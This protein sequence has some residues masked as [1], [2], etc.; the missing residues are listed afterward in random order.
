MSDGGHRGIVLQVGVRKHSAIGQQALDPVRVV[1]AKSGQVVITEL[2][3]RDKE[4]QSNVRTC[5]RLRPRQRNRHSDER[6]QDDAKL[7]HVDLDGRA[8][9][10]YDEPKGDFPFT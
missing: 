7:F 1:R 5:G 8:R 6:E 10:L 3:D 2:I 4:N 9:T